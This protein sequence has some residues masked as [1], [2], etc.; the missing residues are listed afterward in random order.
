MG[1]VRGMVG[2]V[3]WVRWRGTVG[4]VESA[5][6]TVDGCGLL[7]WLQAALLAF[8]CVCAQSK[9]IWNLGLQIAVGWLHDCCHVV[10]PCAWRDAGLPRG[11]AKR[12]VLAAWMLR[13]HRFERKPGHETL[14][15]SV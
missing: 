4:K 2:R 13:G 7:L 11:V 12:I 3:Q 1:W 8:L 15:F 9:E 10:L 6:G 14:C 5:V